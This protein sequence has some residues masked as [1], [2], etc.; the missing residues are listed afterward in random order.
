MMSFSRIRKRPTPHRNS[1]P[2]VH[3]F[4]FQHCAHSPVD[5]LWRCC[6]YPLESSLITKV[7]HTSD[8]SLQQVIHRY[9]HKPVQHLWITCCK[10]GQTLGINRGLYPQ[11]N[12]SLEKFLQALTFLC[13]WQPHREHRTSSC[14]SCRYASSVLLN[15]R[16]SD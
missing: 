5:N 15:C 12:E 16:G 14:I 1:S 7:T 4:S 11:Q 9:P 10:C 2:L 6:F 13:Q 3:P 8:V